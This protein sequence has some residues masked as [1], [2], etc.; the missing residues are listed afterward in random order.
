MNK[1]SLEDALWIFSHSN[2]NIIPSYVVSGIMPADIIGIKKLIYL[3]NNDPKKTLD[4]Y[5]PKKIIVS[6]VFH[7]G[8]LA[9]LEQA[10]KEG[11]KIISIFDDWNFDNNSKTDN[12]QVNL[13]LAKVSD[14][15]V[16]KTLSASK[17]LKQNTNL[18]STVI[19]DMTRFNSAPVSWD[20]DNP[21]RL[22]WF[23]MQSNHDSLIQE[24]ESINNLKF[25]TKLK[26]VT[27]FSNDLGL[28]LK[29]KYKQIEFEFIEWHPN[30]NK[31]IINSNIVIIPYPKDKERLVK[32]SNRIIDSMN[33]GRFVIL[34]D[35]NQFS[36]FR[37]LTYFGNI[38][39]GIE[40][41]VNNKN[42]IKNLVIEA[43]KYVL[44]NYSQEVVAQMW[45]KII[46]EI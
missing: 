37:N 36:E 26:I 14:L 6:K 13:P 44:K 5:K 24:L 39:E 10:K 16:V 45:Q 17:V 7:T 29:N 32:S 41:A 12:T 30:F 25:K 31:E 20:I 33:L 9:F 4:F 1:N 38:A 21:P 8:V 23:G 19:P 34:S 22:I 3:P 11:V 46:E 27:N 40:W 15:I 2:P 42:K 35:V 18:S 43:Q 28:F